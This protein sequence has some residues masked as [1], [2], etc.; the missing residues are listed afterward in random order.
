GPTVPIACPY[1]KHRINLKAAKPGRYRPRCP[2]CERPFALEIPKDGVAYR[3][4][5]LADDAT[6][7]NR[8][9][10]NVA[11]SPVAVAAGANKS[12]IFGYSETNPELHCASNSDAG[13]ADSDPA[14]ERESALPRSEFKG[15]RIMRE[16]AAAAWGPSSSPSNFRSTGPSL[17]RSWPSGGPAT[18]PSWPGS[19]ARPSPPPNLA[20]PISCTSTISARWMGAASSAWSSCRGVRSQ[21]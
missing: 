13:D 20:I 9:S 14:A 7:A 3:A 6:F 21:T 5:V 12:H 11:Q 16:L 17:S 15:Y 8:E 10:P 19:P 4:E 2:K 18:P 1:C